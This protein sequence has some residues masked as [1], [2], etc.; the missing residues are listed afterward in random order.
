MKKEE[1]QREDQLKQHM[2]YY[3]KIKRLNKN[4]IEVNGDTDIADVE[5]IFGINFEVETESAT[6][7]PRTITQGVTVKQKVRVNNT[8]L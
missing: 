3:K 4:T 5:K 7:K 2:K 6:I 1:M 8:L